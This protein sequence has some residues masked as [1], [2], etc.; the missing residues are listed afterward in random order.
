MSMD[1]LWINYKDKHDKS[2]KDELIVHYVELVK[3]IS[4]RL[5]TDY[6]H[7][8]EYDDLVS[9]GI[10][11]LIDA[12]EKFDYTKNVKFETYANIRI[13][14]AIIDQ[15][16]NLDWVPRSLR[17][18]YKKLEEAIDRLHTQNNVNYTDEDLAIELE[19]NVNELGKFLS[20]VST[21]SIVSLEEKFEESIGFDIKADYRDFEPEKSLDIK[22]M[23]QLL[24][25]GIDTL[26][27]RERT[28]ISLYYYDE[29]T[30]KEIALI[31]E[32]S[33][34]RIS[35]LHTKAIARLQ[36]ILKD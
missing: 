10:L 18:K 23:T 8:V 12:I 9:Y 15:L 6:N 13:R 2:A 20:E 25:E 4:G 19:M 16:R 29:L 1:K 36:N 11:G 28:I 5:Y 35:Q 17:H 3:I 31:L 24:K 33:E 32:I 14:G 26:P 22:V 7:H 34:S 27:E 30:Y 21:F